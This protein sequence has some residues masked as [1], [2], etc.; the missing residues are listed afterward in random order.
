MI[1]T[2]HLQIS[3]VDENEDDLNNKSLR[4]ENICVKL[5]LEDLKSSVAQLK[6]TIASLELE[7]VSHYLV[8]N[9]TANALQGHC[10]STTGNS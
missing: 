4:D 3:L 8:K 5:K 6:E 9:S 2:K 7:K 1:S 10:N